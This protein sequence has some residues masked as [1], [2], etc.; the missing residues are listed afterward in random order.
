MNIEGQK[1]LHV[2]DEGENIYVLYTFV[3]EYNA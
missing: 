1:V 2:I 3:T